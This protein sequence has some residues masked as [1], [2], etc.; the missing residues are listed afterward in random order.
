[1]QTPFLSFKIVFAHCGLVLSDNLHCRILCHRC[2]NHPLR[3]PLILL[4]MRCQISRRT[5]MISFHQSIS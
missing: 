2:F 5:N 4:W 1:M 3:G